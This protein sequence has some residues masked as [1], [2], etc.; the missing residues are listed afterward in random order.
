MFSLN[1]C[2]E[3]DRQAKRY[4]DPI[5]ARRYPQALP[6]AAP[7]L[8]GAALGGRGPDAGPA[9]AAAPPERRAEAPPYGVDPPS[10]AGS[11]TAMQAAKIMDGFKQFAANTFSRQPPAE[12][13]R[14]GGR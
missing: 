1:I 8:Q 9:G 5:L 10:P 2:Y 14:V 11:A 4:E 3:F 13:A 7:Q 6:R 12:A